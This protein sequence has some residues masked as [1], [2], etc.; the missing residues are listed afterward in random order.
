MLTK[1]LILSCLPEKTNK[2]FVAY[3][4]GVDSHVLLQLASTVTCLKSKIVAIHIDH[5]LQ[6]GSNQWAMHCEKVASV[7]GV[8]FC[9]IKVTIEK[10]ARES[11]EEMARNAR[12]LA[13]KSFLNKRDVVLLA[14]HR[15]DQME[16]VLLQLFRGAGVRGLSGMPLS[17]G[18]GNGLM[19]RPFLDVS[20][21][22]IMEYAESHHLQW[23]D[24]P[25]NQHNDFDR[26]FLRNQI[27]PQLK[28]RWSALDKT[29]SR[30]ARHCANSD[31]LS[32]QVANQLL[33]QVYDKVD[34]TLII[35]QLLRVD[36]HQQSL[37]IRQWFD[38]MKLRMP[39]EGKIDKILNEIVLA[40]PSANPVLQGKIYTMRRYRNKLYCLSL[41]NNQ[42]KIA[43][44]YWPERIKALN[45][46]FQFSLILVN[47]LGGL[48][49]LLWH[50]A[51]VE[52]KSRTG[53]EKIRLLGREGHH[54]LKKLFQEKGIPPWERER[55]PLI[56]LDDQ[57]AAVADLWAS[58]DF[59]C[60]KDEIGYQIVLKHSHHIE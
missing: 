18:F 49:T 50:G 5:G 43:Y 31:I 45:V 32:Q 51:K 12:Y 6:Q 24:D 9:C 13:F 34:Q 60:E 47:S 20:K 27:I 10:Q 54:S 38:L 59:C 56:Y 41:K 21:K 19:L 15:E 39:S 53:A 7:L 26:N 11:L 48:S 17:I 23:V 33:S 35:D 29:V 44:S 55:I 30:S 2:V 42:F 22:D 8:E 1:D 16:T 28:Q 25:S 3:S 14:Q 46:Q 58:A 57:L 36:V 52:I 37:I 4:G 40:K